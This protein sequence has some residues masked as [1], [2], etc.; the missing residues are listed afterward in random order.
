MHQK[1]EPPPR[2][3]RISNG[4]PPIFQPAKAPD[5][6][7]IYKPG[8]C[9]PGSI[10]RIPP[11]LW[12][13]GRGSS[14]RE[15]NNV[16]RAASE[17]ALSLVGSGIRPVWHGDGAARGF[18]A[19]ECPEALRAY[20]CLRPHAFRA[21]LWRYCVMYTKGGFYLD[22][23]DVPLVPLRSLVRPCDALV[24]TN[25]FCPDFRPKIKKARLWG[26]LR[27]CNESS[28]QIS[29]MAAVPGLPFFRCALQKVIDHVEMGY[30]GDGD[31]HVTGP[32]VAGQCLEKLH[33][34]MDYTM[35]L[36]QGNGA[37]T[38]DGTPVIRTH[39]LRENFGKADRYDS[40]WAR[41]EIYRDGC[42]K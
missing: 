24:L 40:L 33:R 16:T 4:L 17:L 42:R 12:Q 15:H 37:L 41:R 39:L 23:E 7:P 34:R 31:L 32:P 30:Y 27:G 10:S 6:F 18:V 22:A 1:N 5:G 2:E 11:V 25:D 14:L 28:V 36:L 38:L 35:E 29:F 26:G 19:R 3:A 8:S 21:D 20:D 13:T 9:S